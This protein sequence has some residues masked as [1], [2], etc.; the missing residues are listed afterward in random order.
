MLT[1]QTFPRGKPGALVS[2]LTVFQNQANSV[3]A[4]PRDADVVPKTV[5]CRDVRV[6]LFA[7]HDEDKPTYQE[8]NH[9]LTNMHV[10]KNADPF[11]EYLF[12][13]LLY[14]VYIRVLRLYLYCILCCL[15]NLK[16]TIYAVYVIL[17][18]STLSGKIKLDSGRINYHFYGSHPL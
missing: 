13:F 3:L 9:D 11:C 12:A 1:A 10:Y 2:H 16:A 15:Q 6:P 4:P 17:S 14:A 5:V 8:L 7:V 18:S